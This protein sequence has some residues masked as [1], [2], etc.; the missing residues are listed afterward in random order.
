MLCS[1]SFMS[2]YRPVPWCNEVPRLCWGYCEVALRVRSIEVDCLSYD[3]FSALD[4]PWYHI[5]FEYDITEK[6]FYHLCQPS[7][8]K[9]DTAHVLFT[10]TRLSQMRNSQIVRCSRMHRLLLFTVFVTAFQ[11]ITDGL[12]PSGGI[13]LCCPNQSYKPNIYSNW[14]YNNI[15]YNFY[16]KLN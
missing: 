6:I 16:L 15:I 1:S 12:F 7:K 11:R 4:E 5:T 13:S 8:C 3:D 10:F 2:V 9:F 14:K